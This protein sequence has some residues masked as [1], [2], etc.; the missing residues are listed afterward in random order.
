MLLP[1]PFAHVQTPNPCDLM[2]VCKGSDG[3]DSSKDAVLTLPHKVGATECTAVRVPFTIDVQ[4]TQLPPQH[5]SPQC[6][7]QNP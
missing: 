6:R 2:Y 3:Q 7:S 1:E 4:R 5:H